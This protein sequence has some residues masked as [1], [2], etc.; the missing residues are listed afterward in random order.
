VENEWTSDNF[1]ILA[2]FVPKIIT[3]GG[4][5]TKLWR[6]KCFLLGHIVRGSLHCVHKNLYKWCCHATYM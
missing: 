5:L 6:K 3:F 1:I 4:N 2:I